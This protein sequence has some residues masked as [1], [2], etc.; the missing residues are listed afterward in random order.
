MSPD[1]SDPSL[2]LN[3][4]LS[5][6]DF[7]SR[8]LAMAD[9]P[10]VP[11]LERIRFVAIAASNLDE[12]YMVRVANLLGQLEGRLGPPEDTADRRPARELFDAIGAKTTELSRRIAEVL[13]AQL[14]PQL[15]S[16]GIDVI[17]SPSTLPGL[18]EAIAT[19]YAKDVHPVLTPI[20]VDPTHPFPHLKNR[21]LNVAFR[22]EPRPNRSTF[23][24]GEG[25]LLAIV[26][27][28]AVLPR[29]FSVTRPD[30]RIAF[31]GLEVV[32]AL[33]ASELFPG[34][35]VIEA[36][37]FRV[38]RA[39]ELEYIEDEAENLLTTIQQGL[40][41]RDRGAAVR[42]EL[43]AAG[44]LELKNSLSSLLGVDERHVH[45]V[46]LLAPNDLGKIYEA[47]ER[48]ELKDRPFA[49]AT[50]Q[51]LRF[52]RD[53]FRA[54]AERDV[55][56]HHPYESYQHVVD[57]A[58]AA[59]DDPNVVAIKQTLYRTGGGSSPIVRALSRAVQ[60]G[61]QVTALVELKA[62]FDEAANIKWA[63][64]LEQAGVHV[65]YGLIG[66]K[67]HAKLLLV[68][69]REGERLKR[70]LHIATG[71]YNPSTARAYTDF[72]LLTANEDLTRD[73]M[74]LFNVLTGYGDLPPMKHL[75][76][77][78]FD[79]RP[80][81]LGFIEREIA[82]A[83]AGR[84]ARIIAKMNALVD[85]TMIKALYRASQAG[86]QIDLVIR[87][88]CCL[89]PGIPG[90][91]ENIRVRSIVGRFLE[92]A[93]VYYWHNGGEPELRMSSA[94]WMPRNL[95]RRVEVGFPI[96][97]GELKERVTR[98]ILATELSDDVGSWILGPDGR[99]TPSLPSLESPVSAQ[100][101]FMGLAKTRG[102][103]SV[104]T[105][106][107]TVSIDNPLLRVAT[108]AQ[109]KRLESRK[110][111]TPDRRDRG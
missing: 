11:L 75:V 43:G 104:R 47:L 101:T 64:E 14:L 108:E 25:S 23:D 52:Q 46:P 59:A 33:R 58:D 98:E 70:Y 53:P 27:V 99:W 20:A 10:E 12:F 61:K 102:A 74:L 77:A 84:E 69:R 44:S 30:G 1:L 15:A 28:P 26:Q 41:R 66:F 79:M 76:V 16:E 5:W 96:L 9:R 97:S 67:T 54:I 91:S 73:A 87:G 88:I 82:N 56:I 39:A 45:R 17:A 89:R 51:R 13:F 4:E 63:R 22:L 19:H 80:R 24:E 18:D 95:D 106:R 50:V 105:D 111:Q 35:R 42:L 94:D 37:P 62:R 38:T 34:H 65:V 32:L 78:P 103:L 60:N 71:N 40:R 3:R 6:L 109:A 8:V 7:N 100:Q 36:C 81:V 72:S 57:F 55:L 68:T 31:I 85:G 110:S 29:F 49:P 93:R 48:P 2:Y 90:L 21:S 86:V 83:S 107:S 92:H